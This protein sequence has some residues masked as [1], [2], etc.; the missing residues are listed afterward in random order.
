[1]SATVFAP[2]GPRKA[3]KIIWFRFW[4]L[5][6]AA[7]RVRVLAV[8]FMDPYSIG[9]VFK[10]T[11]GAIDREW[12]QVRD[13][14]FISTIWHYLRKA[15]YVSYNPA[16]K[17]IV[18]TMNGQTRNHVL[19]LRGDYFR[20][21]YNPFPSSAPW[22]TDTLPARL[23]PANPPALSA[24]AR[25]SALLSQSSSSG[26]SSRQLSA[27]ST[28]LPASSA[29]SANPYGPIGRP[30]TCNRQEYSHRG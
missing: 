13:Q 23:V 27:G 10:R 30:I 8:Q 1:M 25:V 15:V 5:P 9:E 12:L 14:E 6:Q 19:E 17:E 24:A 4:Q 16:A 7:V 28:P 2:L 18:Y 26:S 3:G 22:I 21:S 20:R 11:Q 29:S